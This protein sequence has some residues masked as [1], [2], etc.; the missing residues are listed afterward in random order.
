MFV[1]FTC[2]CRF[3]QKVFVKDDTFIGLKA[4]FLNCIL[5]PDC[6]YKGAVWSKCDP[7]TGK[8]TLVQELKA[9]TK[10]LNCKKVILTDEIYVEQAKDDIN[11]HDYS[12][13][14]L[15]LF[16]CFFLF[17]NQNG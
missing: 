11:I 4:L 10:A 13:R 9:A 16:V 14:F 8:Q 6:S 7:N 2:L 12:H 3:F 15:L 17:V 1:P 5:N